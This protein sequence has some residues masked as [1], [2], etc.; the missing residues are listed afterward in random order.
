[1]QVVLLTLFLSLLLAT[2]FVLLFVRDRRSQRANLSSPEQDALI[3]F[4]EERF[5]NSKS[6]NEASARR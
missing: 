6:C 4:Q 5:R 2:L 3:P 1:M